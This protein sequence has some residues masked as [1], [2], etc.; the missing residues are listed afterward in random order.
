MKSTKFPISN[1]FSYQWKFVILY[2]VCY[3][4]TISNCSTLDCIASRTRVTRDKLI[5][6]IDFA[7]ACARMTFVQAKIDEVLAYLGGDSAAP[8]QEIEHSS[9][10]NS[11]PPPAPGVN[12]DTA[13]SS[14][15][16]QQTAQ[17][18]LHSQHDNRV[19]ANS[20]KHQAVGTVVE[21]QH[22]QL[23][24]QQQSSNP[25]QHAGLS[26]QVIEQAVSTQPIAQHVPVPAT[27]QA[28][29]A[30]QELPQTVPAVSASPQMLHKPNYRPVHNL[31]PPRII[32]EHFDLGTY[33]V[34]S[35]HGYVEADCRH[36]SHTI[37]GQRNVRRLLLFVSVSV[38]GH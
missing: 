23:G 16:H 32:T 17:G 8:G 12:N 37:K 4:C 30:V 20:P 13:V 36:C 27:T 11:N 7:C 28:T 29:S 14:I 1:L 21:S 10:D 31:R 35:A 33:K 15:T 6:V 5:K 3:S 34:D 26:Q 38:C 19:G 25:A 18:T 2:R 22:T 9:D 24:Q